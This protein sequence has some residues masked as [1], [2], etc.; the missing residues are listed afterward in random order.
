MKPSDFKSEQL[1]TEQALTLWEGMD[2]WSAEV[3]SARL[4]TSHLGA[5]SCIPLVDKV[6]AQAGEAAVRRLMHGEGRLVYVGAGSAGLQ[7][8]V[9]GMELPGT[10]GWPRQRL[11]FLLAGGLVDWANMPGEAEDDTSAALVDSRQLKLGGADVVL[12]VSA[13]G[14][15]P[16]TLAVAQHACEQGALLIGI[17]NTPDSSLTYLADHAVVMSTGQEA[18]MGS[19][20]M[21]A[22]TAQKIALNTLSTLIMARLGYLYDNLMVNLDVSNSKL[23][24]RATAMVARIAACDGQQAGQALEQAD[25]QVPL[26]VLLLAGLEREKA[27]RLLAQHHNRLREVLALLAHGCSG[28]D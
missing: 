28:S 19:T 7:A 24:V 18:V 25:H 27:S 10:Y 3:L 12:A 13:S 26:A 6:I 9:D 16:Y 15:T 22:G 20:R 8:C 11:A 2:Q 14:R 21:Q 4:I 17:C 1:S 5:L 23:L